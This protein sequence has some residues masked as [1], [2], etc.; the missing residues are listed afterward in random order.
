VDGR[1]DGRV[2]RVWSAVAA[3]WRWFRAVRRTRPF[4]GALWLLLGGYDVLYFSRT[5]VNLVIAKG[6]NGSAGYILGGGMM[7]FA[8]VALVAPHYKSLVGL[9][10][11]LLALA[12]F[13]GVNLGGFLIGTV[14]GIL[15]GSMIWGWG[16]KKPRKQ[17]RTKGLVSDLDAPG[18][19]GAT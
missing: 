1:V 4:W 5:P 16:E 15:G 6:F 8:A 14:L 13:I 9:M 19:D 7:L 17:R 3:G 10:G 2:A 18:A 11:V 12:A